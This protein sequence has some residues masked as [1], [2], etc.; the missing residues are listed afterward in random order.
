MQ[1]IVKNWDPQLSRNS[2]L[3]YIQNMNPGHSSTYV[4]V[5]SYTI[6]DLSPGH[7]P[8]KSIHLFIGL[9]LGVRASGF[10]ALCCAEK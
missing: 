3:L 2:L 5:R 10:G 9:R 6:R 4:L 1:S 8:T 7:G